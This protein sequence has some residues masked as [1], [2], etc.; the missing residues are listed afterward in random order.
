M[1]L[2]YNDHT[3]GQLTS[4][5]DQRLQDANYLAMNGKGELR[6]RL[7]ATRRVLHFGVN[8]RLK[9]FVA[10]VNT[11]VFNGECGRLDNLKG[12]SFMFRQYTYCEAHCNTECVFLYQLWLLYDLFQLE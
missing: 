1:R 11:N 7:D 6:P 4:S 8:Q 3:F 10:T 9:E 2:H 12:A 5:I